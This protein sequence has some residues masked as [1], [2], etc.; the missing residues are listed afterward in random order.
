MKKFFLF[1]VSVLLAFTLMAQVPQTINY[2]AV[3]RNSSGQALA[4]QNIKVRVSIL[5]N[6]SPVYTES[7]S[8]TTNSLGLFNIAIG[9]QG[10]TIILGDFGSIVWDQIFAPKLKI[11][12][13]VNNSGLYTTMGIQDISSNPYSLYSALA[14]NTKSLGGYDLNIPG[15]PAAGS[16]LVFNGSAWVATAPAKLDTSLPLLSGIGNVPA[17][18]TSWVFIGGTQ[19]LTLSAGQIV[20]VNGVAALSTSSGTTTNN[21]GVAVCYQNTSGG[22]ITPAYSSS[23]ME[24]G[25]GVQRNSFAAS[26]TIR[27]GTVAY[28]GTGIITPGTYKIGIAVRNNTTFALNTNDQLNG[29]IH[30]H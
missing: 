27:V 4:N 23:W 30:L 11:E 10:G 20:D 8:V 6:T 3:A 19:T 26:A 25:A 14:Y 28:P 9:G 21:V 5:N 2:Q 18:S 22:P 7:W 29:F 17:N 12:L 15:T 13:D 16:P 1:S 24:F